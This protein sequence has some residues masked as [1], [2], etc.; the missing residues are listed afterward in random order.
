MIITDDIT[1]QNYHSIFIDLV[2]VVTKTWR[3]FLRC[4]VLIHLVGLMGSNTIGCHHTN[5]RF[6]YVE[7]GILGKLWYIWTLF[8]LG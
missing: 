2:F 4:T 5:T 8:F 1:S 7:Y 3:T 6:P